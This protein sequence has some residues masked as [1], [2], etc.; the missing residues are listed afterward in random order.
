MSPTHSSPSRLNP[1]S[2]VTILMLSLIGLALAAA[3]SQSSDDAPEAAQTETETVA[4]EESSAPPPPAQEVREAI[5]D[6]DSARAD[7]AAAQAEDDSDTV[8]SVQSGGRLAP[9]PILLPDSDTVTVQSAGNPGFRLL[10]DGYYASY[11]GEAYNIVIN[12]TNLTA[13]R[14]GEQRNDRD[15]MVVFTA[16]LGGAQIALSRYG[17][18]YLVEFECNQIDPE[19]RTCISEADA[20]R[21]AEELIVAGTR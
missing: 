13:G 3:C 7:F 9:I 14:T 10:A 16:T 5:I 6:W 18:D 17:A 12:G 11:P 19:T 8:F 21:I 1:T 2:P 15:G 20:R 4:T